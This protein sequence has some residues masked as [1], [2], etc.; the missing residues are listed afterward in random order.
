MSQSSMALSTA[1]AEY[2][3]AFLASCEVVWLQ[4]ILYELFDL[5]LDVA[6]IFYE[7]QSCMKLSENLVFHH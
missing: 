5:Q 2:V 1:E 4:N 7:N 6:F 3:S